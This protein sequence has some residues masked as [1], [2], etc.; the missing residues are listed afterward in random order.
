MRLL[1]LSS[2]GREW[3]TAMSPGT[4]QLVSL[5]SNTSILPLRVETPLP[6][7]GQSH[8]GLVSTDLQWGLKH[9]V[10]AVAQKAV[11]GET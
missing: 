11:L 9:F 2:D 10:A 7:T 1:S 8:A 6:P 4:T 3:G 5:S